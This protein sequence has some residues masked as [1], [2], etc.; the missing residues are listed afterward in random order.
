MRGDRKGKS[1][2]RGGMSGKGEEVLEVAI[3]EE[4][5]GKRV[6]GGSD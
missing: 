6:E 1:V 5:Q 2:K 4:C 3:S